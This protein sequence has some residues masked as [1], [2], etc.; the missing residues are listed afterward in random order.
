MFIKAAI[1]GGRTKAEHALVPVTPEEQAA[2]VVECLTAG[3]GAVHLH[4]RSQ[5]GVE[6]LDPDDVARTLRAVKSAAPGSA[7]GIS[8]GASLPKSL[9]GAAGA[10]NR[11][12]P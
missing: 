11:K 7:I 9:V 8:T 4:V 1:N 5:P 10:G 6:S 12:D 3:A 2:A